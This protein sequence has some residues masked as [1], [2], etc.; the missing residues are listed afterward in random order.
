MD[1]AEETDNYSYRDYGRLQNH[2]VN[3]LLAE[4][5]PHYGKTAEDGEKMYQA[6]SSG[7]YPLTRELYMKV[8]N[9]LQP[10]KKDEIIRSLD[11]WDADIQKRIDR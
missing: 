4:L 9:S 1:M 5:R 2:L 11:A 10:S 8:V 3:A 6:V 7:E